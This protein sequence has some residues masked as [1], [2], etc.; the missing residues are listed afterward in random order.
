MGTEFEPESSLIRDLKVGERVEVLEWDKRH[1][2]TG[3]TRLK[4]KA[5]ADGAV[6]WITKMVSDEEP[7]L[8][9]SKL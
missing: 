6:G 9:P 2:Q 5:V 4:V 3:R 7:V 1:E 8:K